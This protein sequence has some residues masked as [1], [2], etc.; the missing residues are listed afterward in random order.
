MILNLQARPVPSPWVNLA[1]VVPVGSIEGS[2]GAGFFEG[3]DGAG[4]VEGSDA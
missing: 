4:E 2:D 1:A 3:S